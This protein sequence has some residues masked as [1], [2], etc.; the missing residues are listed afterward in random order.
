MHRS[1]SIRLVSLKRRIVCVSIAW[2]VST[3]GIVPYLFAQTSAGEQAT[4]ESRYIVDM[5]TAG[6][7]QRGRF[8]LDGYAFGNSGVM[9]EC[10]VSPLTNFQLGISY[11][12]SGFLGNRSIVFQPWPGFHARFRVLDETLSSPALTFGFSSQ[13]RGEYLVN[14]FLTHSPGIFATASKNFSFLGALAIH[15][16]ITYSFDPALEERFPNIYIGFEKTLGSIA[17]LAVEYNPTLD[18][19]TVR[20]RGGLLNTT[21]RV[22]TGRGFTIELQLRDVLRNLPNAALPYRMVRVEFVGAF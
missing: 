6:V 14:R 7:L 19:P 18:D 16:G 12:G 2:I 15:G 22:S 4:V 8:A 9:V 20:M 5:P 3:A 11:S 17:S 1:Y 13:G 10:T 21:L